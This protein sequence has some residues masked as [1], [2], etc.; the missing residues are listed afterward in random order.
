MLRYLSID[1]G[2]TGNPGWVMIGRDLLQDYRRTFPDDDRE[3]LFFGATDLG[4]TEND[5]RKVHRTQ[6]AAS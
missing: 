1:K 5:G 3:V 4:Q 6:P 2:V